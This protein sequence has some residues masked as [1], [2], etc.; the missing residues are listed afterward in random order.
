MSV[1]RLELDV[2]ARTASVRAHPRA[3]ALGNVLVGP[4]ALL[5]V[6]VMMW[7][8]LH[9]PVSAF[10]FRFAY[11]SAGHR[12]LAGLSPYHWTLVQY[13]KGYAFVYPA[14][15]AI[16]F[17]PLALLPK[18]FGTVLFTLVSAALTPIALALLRVR[19]W[20]VYG[21]TLLWMPVCAGWMT[22][23][24]SLFL[25]LGLTCMWRL[26]DRPGAA[27]FLTAAMIS[28]KPLMWP[29]AL[30]LLCTRRWRAS[31][32][33][34]GYGLG[35]NIA[36]WWLVGFDQIGSYL[37]AMSIDTDVAWRTGFGVPALLGY[38]GAG[39]TAGI[40]LMLIL[41]AALVA[42]IVHSGLVKRDQIQALALTLA[43]AIV[44]SPLVWNHYLVL[45]IVPLALL[46]PR[47]N[48]LWALPVLLWVAPQDV[49]VHLWQAAVFWTVVSTILVALV[50]RPALRRVSFPIRSWRRLPQVQA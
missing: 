11:W 22:A 25:M 15:S 13:R 2:P 39:R 43:L 14:L 10:D 48:W 46:R 41:S 17:A 1:S 40:A 3:R 6:V 24:E 19:D 45:L 18:A 7:A 37:H 49:R 42:A 5:I 38:L 4:V 12:V 36:A 31:A 28:L 23:N 32:H 50:M 8:V 27:G 20:R 9:G 35:L 34:L 30:W 47:L 33:M 29:L 26:R 21:I 44:S 16:V